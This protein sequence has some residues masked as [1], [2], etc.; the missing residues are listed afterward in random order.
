[1]RIWV[2]VLTLLASVP[3]LADSQFHIKHSTKKDIPP[4][5]G[6]CDIR[7]QVDGEVEA[8]IR[9]DTVSL[10]TVSGREARDDGSECNYP[11]PTREVR[12]FAFQAVDSRNQTRLA[13]EPDSRNDFTAMVRIQDTAAGYGRYHFRLT[14]AIS[15]LTDPDRPTVDGFVW[16]NAAHYAGR[17]AGSAVYGDTNERKLSDVT[18]DLDRGGRAI[19]SLHTERG[20]SMVVSGY[21]ISREGDRIKVDAMTDDRKLRGTMWLTVNEAKEAVLAVDLEATDGQDHVKV[22]WERKAKL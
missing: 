20:F 17:G 3:V 16:N 15:A 22:H 1:M 18:V 11:L 13:Q 2:I 19:V 12:G 7:L 10:H 14:W 4:G 8:A 21:V 5:K 6:L 9:G